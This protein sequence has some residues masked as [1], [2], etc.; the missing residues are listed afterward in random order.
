MINRREL[1]K[2]A[3]VAFVSSSA[4]ACG[5]SPSNGQPQSNANAAGQPVAAASQAGGDNKQRTLSLMFHGPAVITFPDGGKSARIAFVAAHDPA[6]DLPIHLPSLRIEDKARVKCVGR[7]TESEW[8]LVGLHAKPVVSGSFSAKEFDQQPAP[9]EQPKGTDWSSLKW[10]PMLK[11][12]IDGDKLERYTIASVELTAGTLQGFHPYWGEA[13]GMQWTWQTEAA[14]KKLQASESEL[15]KAPRNPMTDQ[16]LLSVP[17][18]GNT[19]TLRFNSIVAP[20]ASFDLAFS[21]AGDE[22]GLRFT[23]E[24]PADAHPGNTRPLL[25]PCGYYFFLPSPPPYADRLLPYQVD[26]MPVP[27]EILDIIL[28]QS[29]P[30]GRFEPAQPNAMNPV[31]YPGGGTGMPSPRP[32][33]GGIRARLA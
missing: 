7:E 32:N 33:C 4:A 9:R 10:V 21:T 29:L 23:S 31:S 3:S 17:F 28:K 26:T 22:V 8:K 2:A 18:T 16:I 25:L 1:L 6:C 24:A 11:D 27:Q 19:V 20:Q 12:P 14:W 15:A 5:S 30:L 13:L